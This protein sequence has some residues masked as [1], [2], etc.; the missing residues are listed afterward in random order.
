MKKDFV[1]AV[2]WIIKIRVGI[3]SLVFVKNIKIIY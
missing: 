2:S 3:V 1:N